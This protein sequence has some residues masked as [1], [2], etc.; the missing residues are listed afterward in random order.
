MISQAAMERCQSAPWIQALDHEAR[1]RLEGV[2][3]E[4]RVEPGS[5]LFAEGQTNDRV[6]VLLDGTVAVHRTYTG[7]APELVTRITPPGLFGTTTF[8]GG[9]PSRVE[10]RAETPV[11]VLVLDRAQ[12]DALSEADPRTAAQFARSVIGDLA[13]RFDAL[14][15]RVSEFLAHPPSDA[16]RRNEWLEFRSKFFEEAPM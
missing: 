12:F 3:R 10:A 5:V 6:F 11:W 16:R 2:V 1:T 7:H 4:V 9:K 14:D 8:F 15:R 13:E